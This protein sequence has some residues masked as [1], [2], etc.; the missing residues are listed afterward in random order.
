MK[1]LDLA[2][3]RISVKELL[4]LASKGCVRIISSDG[5]AF[6]LEEADGFDKEVKQLNASKNF[7][8][9]LDERSKQPATKSLQDYGKSLE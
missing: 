5:H 7:R 2:Q 6:V 9:F 8:R 1:T 4:K 3:E